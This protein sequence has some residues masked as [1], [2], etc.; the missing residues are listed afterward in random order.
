MKSMPIALRFV[1]SVLLLP[2]QC[3]YLLLTASPAYADVWGYVD[4]QGKLHFS[5]NRKDER[6]QPFLRSASS[7][8]ASQGD[9]EDAAAPLPMLT[10]WHKLMVYFQVSP[11]YKQVKHLLRQAAKEYRIEYELL[12]ALIMTESGFDASA[13]SPKG[14]VGLMQIMPTT[15]M[16]YGLIHDRRASV[17]QKLAD[18]RVNIHIGARVL[19]DLLARF[20]AR[21]DLAL[22]AYNAGPGAVQRAGNR[23]PNY[24]ETRNYV[25]TILQRYAVL[26]LP[27]LVAAQRRVR[28][29]LH[30][31]ARPSLAPA[32]TAVAV[33][34]QSFAINNI[35]SQPF[36]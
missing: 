27:P 1:S 20:P 3:L 26:R 33:A 16:M 34:A 35:P 29:R 22:A 13:V 19:R 7:P 28:A 23:V 4:E 31:A 9:G 6:Y 15:A 11:D 17:E 30:L 5:E 21:L 12:Q 8:A 10:D 36:D 14:A 25:R 32:P 18:P 2:L 24:P